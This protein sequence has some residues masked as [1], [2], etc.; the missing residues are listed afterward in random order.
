MKKFLTIGCFILSVQCLFAQE[1]LN[2]SGSSNEH[3][4]YVISWS[5]GE[6][7][8]ETY[9]GSKSFLTQG[10]LQ[11]RLDIPTSYFQ[12]KDEYDL[13]IYPNPV[14]N[15]SVSLSIKGIELSNLSYQLFDISGRILKTNKIES[16]PASIDMTN[17]VPGI[18]LLRISGD[19][20]EIKTF[21]IIKK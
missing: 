6:L 5:I 9:T 10:F 21:K 20:K 11:T 3:S 13:E 4:G 8:A 15:N 1:V 2:A 17:L 7:V 16:N 12:V 18:Y 19:E 14:I